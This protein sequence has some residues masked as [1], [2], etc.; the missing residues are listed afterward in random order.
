MGIPMCHVDVSKVRGTELVQEP[1]V[2]S[3]AAPYV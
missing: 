1:P 2:H 3:A